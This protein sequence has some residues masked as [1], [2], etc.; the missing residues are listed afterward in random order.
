MIFG[1]AAISRAAIWRWYSSTVRAG[2]M[3]G[4]GAGTGAGVARAA[5]AGTGARATG[6]GGVWQA[7]S[8]HKPSQAA[9]ARSRPGARA[10]MSRSVEGTVDLL[11]QGS[12][13]AIDGHQLFNAR[14]PDAA[15][16][17]EA[18]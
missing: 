13:N 15:D 8:A 5:G 10:S 18:L 3:C 11:G 12:R 7:D 14:G 9:T 6:G 4:A 16:T 2:R 17:A 1:L